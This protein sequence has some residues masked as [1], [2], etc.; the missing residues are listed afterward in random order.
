MLLDF[1]LTATCTPTNFATNI[2]GPHFAS[3][4]LHSVVCHLPRA[5]GYKAQPRHKN[6]CPA[7]PGAQP[8]SDIPFGLSLLHVT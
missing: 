7:G 4:R 2:F 5:I 8:Q 1:R 3:G 6:G